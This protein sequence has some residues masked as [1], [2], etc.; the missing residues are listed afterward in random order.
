[1]ILRPVRGVAVWQ[2]IGIVALLLRLG[3]GVATGG[4]WRPE[5]NE[6]DA[7]ARNI[8][9][10]DGFTYPHLGVAYHSYAPPLYSW[11]TAAAYWATG[12]ILAVMLLQVVAGTA[13]AAITGV[14]ATRLF[15]GWIA[16]AAAGMLVALHPG[17]VV[18]NATKAHPLTFDAFFFALVLLQAF[19]LAER[20]T[21]RRAAELGMIVGIGT[22][23]RGT[24]IIFLP[25]VCM[26]LL[27]MK[28]RSSRRA[29][30]RCAVVA[31]LCTAAVVAPWTIRNSVLH[32]RFVFLVTVDSEAFWRGNNPYATGHS[33]IDAGRTV[34]GALPED[35]MR[36]LLRQ[37]G[38][39]AQAA[40]FATRASSF[41]QA[42]PGAF[43]RL[44]LLKFLHFWW[45]A[46]Q[47]GLLYPRSWFQVYVMYYVAALLLATVGIW[48]F[49]RA[50]REARAQAL[51]I[52]AF[53]LALSALQ[54]LYYVEGRH[55]WAVESMVLALAGGG[56]AALTRRCE[57]C[58]LERA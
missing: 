9:A 24:I 4:L 43:I 23:S 35:E 14:I 52:G 2:I 22:L 51:L 28:P 53:L 10:G 6:Y 20:P 11:I 48:R 36:D 16:G 1:M 50:S 17:L 44:T 37:P 56:V 21:M 39:L 29:A 58:V 8:L 40:W 25:I 46:P 30:M 33:Y 55:R 18:Y 31:G 19:R 38:E 47:T 12:S 3:A 42:D 57:I 34:L 45:V 13:L 7:I 15:G 32:D 54:S 26:W 5:L 49:A 41:I 27:I